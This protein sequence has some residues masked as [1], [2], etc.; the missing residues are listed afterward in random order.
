MLRILPGS[1]NSNAWLYPPTMR[2]AIVGGS[3]GGLTAALLLRDL[4]H[5]VDVFERATGELT[6]FGAGI[7][8][9]PVS[10]RYVVERTATSLASVT[11]PVHAYRLL[12]GAGRLLW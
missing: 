3:M 12:D 4:G 11:V 9:H 1:V 10:V 5:D 8:A 2:I 7:V 6:G